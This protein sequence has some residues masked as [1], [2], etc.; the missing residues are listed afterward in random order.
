MADQDRSAAS[1][2][3]YWLRDALN[4]ALFDA[5]DTEDRTVLDVGGGNFYSRLK[6]RGFTWSRYVVLEPGE[7]LLPVSDETVECVVASAES[8]P[9]EDETFDLILAI[10]VL[11]HVFDPIAATKEMYRT[12]REGGRLVVLV[13]QSGALHLV[14]HH[15]SNLTRFWLFEQADRLGAQIELW[16]PIG[17]AWRTIASRLFLMFWPVLD[18]HSTRDHG[19]PRRSIGFWISL[20]LQILAAIVFFPVAL[21]LSIFD[22]KEEANN[23][24]FVLSKPP[25]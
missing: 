24:L 13:P 25:N 2:F 21:L 22:I 19:L 3:A 12:L 7:E 4:G 8:I 1:R 16:K 20:P 5:I 14:P 23:H 18:V 11:E 15:Y 6:R 9:Y 10:Q 17:G